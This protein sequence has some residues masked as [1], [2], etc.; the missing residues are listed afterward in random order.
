[1]LGVAIFKLGQAANLFAKRYELDRLPPERERARGR[2]ARCS[3]PAS[4]P[5]TVK[6]IEF[7]PVDATRRATCASRSRSTRR[8]QEQIR[9][10]LEGQAPHA[11]PPRRQG[12]RHLAG[13]A[14]LRALLDGRH[15]HD[16]AVARLRGD[17]R[18]GERRGDRHGRAH[19]R[20]RSITGGIVRGEG[21]IGQLITNRALYDQLNG[22]LSAREH[23]CSRASRIRTARSGRCSTTRRSTTASTGVIGSTDSLVIAINSSKGTVGMLLRDTTL[24]RNLVGITQGADSLMKALAGRQGHGGQAAHRPDALR[25]AQ[26]AGDGLERDPRR[27]PQGSEQVHEGRD[28]GLLGQAGSAVPLSVAYCHSATP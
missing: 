4:S 25:S 6:S 13:H 8:L 26:Q 11:R 18:A 14:A 28:Q 23:A 12:V 24:Y 17:D 3:S 22:T 27:R 16:G 20:L 1:M 9:A 10:R 21:T 19:A 15:G 5:A 7:L 2:A